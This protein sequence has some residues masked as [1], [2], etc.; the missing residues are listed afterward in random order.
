MA[1]FE[2]IKKLFQTNNQRET[3]K[4]KKIENALSS[5][6]EISKQL[7]KLD[8]EYKSKLPDEKKYDLEKLFPT[9]LNLE[10]KNANL[11]TDEQLKN[12]AIQNIEDKILNEK[13]KVKENAS[14]KIEKLENVKTEKIVD[15]KN[16]IEELDALFKELKEKSKNKF[17][18]SGVGRSSIAEKTNET[19]ENQDKTNKDDQK[20]A[21]VKE[22]S[23]LDNK[24][25]EETSRLD[26][27][28]RKIDIEQAKDTK[29][30]IENLKQNRDKKAL[31][32]EKYNAN[33]EKKQNQY[34]LK[35]EKDVEKFLNE[36]ETE[37]LEKKKAQD[38][39]EKKYGY[40]GEKLD[41]YSKRYEIALNFYNSLSPDIAAAALQ[42]S[43]SMKY[44]LGN[45]YSKLYSILKQKGSSVNRFY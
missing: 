27:A 44:Y 15:S 6:K 43:P 8:D 35:R 32:I 26:E 24:I 45:Y 19:L 42:A 21:L 22:L 39:Y 20:F 29:K 38:E 30:Q 10:K 14:S 5:E 4:A 1:F 37:K 33:I 7:K 36:K 34:I 25:V 17:V 28:L 18:S 16:K 2:E 9:T 41:N 13:N 12:L 11:Q 23:E 40:I 31:E 3:E